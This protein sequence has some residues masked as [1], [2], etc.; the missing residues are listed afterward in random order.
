[1]DTI[2]VAGVLAAGPKELSPDQEAERALA[3]LPA[4]LSRDPGA[5]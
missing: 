2:D 4:H 1:M 5:G 3:P